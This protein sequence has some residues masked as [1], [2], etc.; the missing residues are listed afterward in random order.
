LSE[1]TRGR[2]ALVDISGRLV[3]EFSLAHLQAGENEIV[4]DGTDS[5]GAAVASGIYQVLLE[6][7]TGRDVG[8][9]SLIK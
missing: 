3:R 2:L 9:I 8:R 1:R 5:R 6:T 7:E 4:W